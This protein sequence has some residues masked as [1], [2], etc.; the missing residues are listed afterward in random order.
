MILMRGSC[1]ARSLFVT[2]STVVGSGGYQLLRHKKQGV[3]PRRRHNISAQCSSISWDTKKPRYL[4]VSKVGQEGQWQ[5]QHRMLN[6]P[7]F[8]SMSI[9][10]PWKCTRYVATGWSSGAKGGVPWLSYVGSKLNW[11]L[12]GIRFASRNWNLRT[13]DLGQACKFSHPTS[14]PRVPMVPMPSSQGQKNSWEKSKF[15]SKK[16]VVSCFQVSW[17]TQS[18]G[19]G[20]RVY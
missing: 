9:I 6:M 20:S 11:L 14:K 17:W 2:P 10:A 1:G 4:M 8:L 13:L 5:V 7:G 16:E 18:I 3:M 19:R 15:W 12:T